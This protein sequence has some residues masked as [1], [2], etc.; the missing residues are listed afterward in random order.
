MLWEIDQNKSEKT[1][2]ITQNQ[3]LVVATVE[4][5]NQVTRKRVLSFLGD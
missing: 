2:L 5:N 1:H 3:R 4:R